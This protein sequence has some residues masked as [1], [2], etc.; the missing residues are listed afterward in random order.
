[1]LGIWGYINC[2]ELQGFLETKT[3]KKVLHT[4]PSVTLG[5]A[6]TWRKPVQTGIL[7][8]HLVRRLPSA[9]PR[10][11]VKVR[12]LPSVGRMHSAN[13][14]GLPSV[15]ITTLGKQPPQAA[16]WERHVSYFC[17]VRAVDTRQTATAGSAGGA[18]RVLCL[19]SACRRHSAKRPLGPSAV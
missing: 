10:H 4:L 11:S 14:K 12:G 18:P 5:K 15:R 6:D 7:G 9:I 13:S 19:P 16:L 3:K 17:R 1:M 8:C 2:F